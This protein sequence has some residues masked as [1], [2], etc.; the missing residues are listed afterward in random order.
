MSL[1][2]QKQVIDTYIN[3]G[4]GLESLGVQRQGDLGGWMAIVAA[5]TSTS[6]RWTSWS[7][8]LGLV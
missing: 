4:E 8:K 1:D 5:D 7:T 6:S 3:F 2:H